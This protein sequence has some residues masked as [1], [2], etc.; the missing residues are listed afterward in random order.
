[1]SKIGHDHF[2]RSYL[3]P[4]EIEVHIHNMLQNYAYCA[5]LGAL[6][7]QNAGHGNLTDP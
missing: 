3:G 6:R 2:F 1:M 4:S 5:L 7:A